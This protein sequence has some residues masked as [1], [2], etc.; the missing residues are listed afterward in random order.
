MDTKSGYPF[1][2]I[3]N[4]LLPTYPQVDRDQRCDVA[5][6]GGGITSA[7]IAEELSSHGH[8]VIVIEQRDLG[9]GSTAASTALIQY[10]IDVHM[11]EL[12]KRYDERTAALAYST[13][14]EATEELIGLCRSIRDVGF[15]RSDSVYLASKARDLPKLLA[16]HQLRVRHG[17]PSRYLEPAQIRARYGLVAPGALYSRVAAT[18]DPY[19][20]TCRL[21][22][23]TH[24][25]GTRIFDRTRVELAG[26]TSRTVA[27]RTD[28]GF[29]IRADHLIVAAGYEGQRWLSRRVARNRSSY[30][31]VTDPVSPAQLAPIAKT[32][33]WESA[34]PYHYLRT[35]SDRRIIVGGEDDAVDRPAVRDRRVDKRANSLHR[36][37]NKLF[38]DLELTRAFA[39]AGTFAETPD[40]L[41]FFGPHEQYGDRVLFA[42]AYGGNGITYSCLGAALLR[43]II[44]KRPHPL[45]ELYAFERIR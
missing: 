42:M 43:S 6:V 10:E 12:A 40:G 20:F 18:L 32:I 44:E 13:C 26:T 33:L 23:R 14:V 39:W 5:I 28:R 35:T 24:R 29:E 1:W 8:D 3:K 22:A 25:R 2:V 27:L 31:F 34:R 9:W 7:L 41:P 37:A 15:K 30:A 17:I 19:R 4:G 16:E 36:Y 11:T 45:R 21:F 38:P